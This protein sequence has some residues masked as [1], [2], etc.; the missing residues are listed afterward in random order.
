[1]TIF[2]FFKELV[3]AAIGV[4]ILLFI[5]HQPD[6]F[7]HLPPFS[8]SCWL[9][10]IVFSIGVYFYGLRAA[11]SPNR[12]AFTNATIG[13]I[14]LKMVSSVA[15]VFIYVKINKPPDA[16]FIIPFFINYL[17]FTIF[18]T[19]FMILLGKIRPKRPVKQNI[20]T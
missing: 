15:F 12:Q 13:F 10:F 6:K 1:L 5:L 18:E 8:W 19:R 16:L 3:I 20:G 2:N 11:R 4:A 9:F 14:F 7:S 17:C